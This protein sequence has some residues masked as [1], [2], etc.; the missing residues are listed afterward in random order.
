MAG[1]GLP[2]DRRHRCLIRAVKK[3]ALFSFFFLGFPPSFFGV[4]GG[5]WVGQTIPDI[6]PINAHNVYVVHFTRFQV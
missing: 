2:L 1:M 5:G 4:G 6:S 3:I